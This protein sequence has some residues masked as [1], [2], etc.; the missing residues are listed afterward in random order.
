MISAATGNE[1]V[2]SYLIS[3][4][5]K[6]DELDV[7][8][9]SAAGIAAINEK[10]VVLKLMG[11]TGANLNQLQGPDALPLISLAAAVS[12]SA[13]A[14]VEM[15]QYLISKGADVNQED[16]NGHTPLFYAAN[17]GNTQIVELL[18]CT[19]ADIDHLN[20]VKNVTALNGAVVETKSETAQFL[21]KKGAKVNL[22]VS[23]LEGPA[24]LAAEVR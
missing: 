2:V 22:L 8:E 18:L 13:D 16:S 3:S 12:V 10:S 17:S 9:T 6:L 21:I 19:G 1:E 14:G 4:G 11:D 23:N 20:G 5:A 24:F 15:V 7:T